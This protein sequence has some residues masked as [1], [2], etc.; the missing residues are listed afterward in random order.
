MALEPNSHFADAFDVD[1]SGLDLRL[2]VP[3]GEFIVHDVHRDSPAE[4]AG[5][6]HDDRIVT[7]DGEPSRRFTLAQVTK[8]F[9]TPD[10]HIMLGLQRGSTRTSCV[11]VT[12]KAL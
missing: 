3:T 10:R 5:I 2:D 11:I 4:H 1:A 6:L 7:I 12:R 8:M 9:Q